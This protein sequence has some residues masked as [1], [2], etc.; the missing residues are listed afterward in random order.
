MAASDYSY[1]RNAMQ[2]VCLLSEH[3]FDQWPDI[4]SLT[5]YACDLEDAVH[6]L[7]ESMGARLRKDTFNHWMVTFEGEETSNG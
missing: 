7:A 2:D 6:A 3:G 5:R 1:V 4:D